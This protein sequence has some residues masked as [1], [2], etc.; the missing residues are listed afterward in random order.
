MLILRYLAM[1]VKLNN[2]MIPYLTIPFSFKEE[3]L[4][5]AKNKVAP[6]AENYQKTAPLDAALIEYYNGELQEWYESNVYK[7]VLEHLKVLGIT[8]KPTIQ[9]F[10]YKKLEKM[11]PLPW[12]GN[13]HIDTY[14]GVDEVTTF[15]LNILIEGDDDT[16]M[17]WW[18]IHDRL[19]DPRLHN[20]KFPK[21]EDP[22]KFSTRC[23]AVGETK[24]HRW[25]TAGK[26]DWSKKHL[27]KQNVYA[28]FVRTDYLHAL[29]WSGK[30]PRVIL[31]LRFLEPWDTNVEALRDQVQELFPQ[32]LA[33]RG[34]SS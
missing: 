1:K 14:K 24:E 34:Q 26:P 31:S 29:N 3:T 8:E 11:Y 12:L 33:L 4:N 13:P 20:V 6:I 17:V 23:Q 25:I 22:T 28:S 27:A 16:E 32:L 7:E 15:R 18:N 5:W 9:F 30:N 10:I 21:P 2:C 19:N